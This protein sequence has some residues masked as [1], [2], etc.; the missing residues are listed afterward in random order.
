MD[1]ILDHLAALAKHEGASSKVLGCIVVGLSCLHV[2][3]PGIDELFALI[4]HHTV[5]SPIVVFPL[6]FI[7]N[8]ATANFYEGSLAKAVVSTPCVIALARLLERLWTLRS[9]A[10]H[11]GFT[12]A[13]TGLAHFIV[14]I[15][16][17]H[18]AQH[19]RDFFVPVQSCIGLIISLS[20]GLRH[21]YPLEALPHLPRSWGLQ[22]QHLPFGFTVAALVA[23]LLVP[24][25]MPEWLFAPFALFF[26]WL[27]IRYVMWF[28]YAQA[29]GDH[30]P[31]FTFAVLFPKTLRPIIGCFG[32]LTHRVASCFLPGVVKLRQVD[33]SLGNPIMYDPSA[34]GGR[35]PMGHGGAPGNMSLGNFGSRGHG[36]SSGLAQGSA[37]T[38]D[39]SDQA[40]YQ[41]RRA[42]ALAL[43]DENINALLNPAA[44]GSKAVNEDSPPPAAS[45]ERGSLPDPADAIWRTTRETGIGPAA[46]EP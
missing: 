32:G 9:M 6:P 46:G 39:D 44:F 25:A 2:V 18:S 15:F 11:L 14:Q 3:A 5:F 10:A 1:A 27:H 13:C 38:A 29:Y 36:A 41:A 31:E 30:S 23:G 26:A 22:Y 34:G 40:A 12:A 42:K 45:K 28:P 4:P 8:L 19:E 21:A 24:T 43:L 17:V 35:S 37:G 20:V 16:R 7:W 33:A